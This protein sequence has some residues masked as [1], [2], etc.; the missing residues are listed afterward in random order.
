MN[1][2]A[3]VIGTITNIE[4]INDNMQTGGCTIRY[5][6]DGEYPFGPFQV[7]LSPNAFVLNQHLL[8]V[9]DRATFFFDKNAPMVLIYPPRYDAIAA[10]YTPYGTSAMLD[11]FQNHLVNSDNTLKLNLAGDTPVTL[12]NGQPFFGD[13]NGHLLLVLYSMTTRS[14]PAQTTPDQVA[15]FC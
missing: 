4:H 12:P 11:V 9:G 5:T 1:H 10:A 13:P 8:Q 6:M 3:S 15:V 2:Y 7:Q 14:I